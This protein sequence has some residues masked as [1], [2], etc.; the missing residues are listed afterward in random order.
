VTDF[1][2]N[3]YFV[4]K[5]T[6]GLYRHFQHTHRFRPDNGGTRV[7]DEIEFSL[8]FGSLVDKLVGMPTLHGTF[9]K[10]HAA[11]LA[12]FSRGGRA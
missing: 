8:G 6:H 4:D 1:K 11:L 9:K 3:E 5:M 10:R 2:R 7:Q 12:H